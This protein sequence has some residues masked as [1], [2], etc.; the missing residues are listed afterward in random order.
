MP[1]RSNSNN[2]TKTT[3]RNTRRD[4]KPGIDILEIIDDNIGI[5]K[6]VYIKLNSVI[7]ENLMF[8]KLFCLK[9]TRGFGGRVEF[10]SHHYSCRDHIVSAR[11]D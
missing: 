2:K 8:S 6:I 11:V 5:S 3:T 10:I 1:I 4:K 9:L 7:Q